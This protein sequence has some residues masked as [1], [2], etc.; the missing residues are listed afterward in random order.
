M[1]ILVGL[2]AVHVMAFETKISAVV[3]DE[4][5][6]IA[7]RRYILVPTRDVENYTRSMKMVHKVSAVSNLLP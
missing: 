5:K 3:A 7:V 1:M 4:I 6:V 2:Q